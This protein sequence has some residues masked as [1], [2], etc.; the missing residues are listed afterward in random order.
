MNTN[1]TNKYEPQILRQHTSHPCYSREFVISVTHM[2]RIGSQ[3]IDIPHKTEVS[4][5][6]GVVT[7][8]G[9]KG[10]LSRPLKP[11]VEVSID[12]QTVSLHPK[13]ASSATRS[14]WGTYASH[15]QNMIHGVNELFEKRLVIQGVGYRAQ[16]NGAQLELHVGFS[17]PVHMPIP[18]DLTVSVEEGKISV[19]GINK[20]RV[21]QFA[22]RVRG[23]KPPEPYKGK[24]IRYEDETIRMKEGKKSV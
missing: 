23:V 11:R 5:Q 19:S 17:H 12:E 13:D 24:G 6:D 2:S 14:L 9:P 16:V 18:E 3:Q 4:Y 20:E 21:G 15:I 22:A 8:S 10:T 7:V 1:Y